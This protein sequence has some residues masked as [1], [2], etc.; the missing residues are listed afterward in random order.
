MILICT[1][2]IAGA[3]GYHKSV[4]QLA[5]GLHGA[6]YSVALLGF[7]GPS[8]GSARA[9]PLWPL[10]PGVPAFALQTLAA[11]GG[12]LL[13]RNY[14]LALSG[15]LGSTPYGFTANQLAVLR[16][17]NAAL[18]P[19]DTI[20]FT[21]AVQA[22]AFQSALETDERRPRT[23]L[24]I[25]GDYLHHSFLWDL[26][27]ET[28]GV[29]DRLQTVADGLRA[30]FV[31]TFDDADVVYVPNFPGDDGTVVE[32]VEHDGVNIALPA[33]FQARKNQLD[34]VRA[35]ALVD[36]ESVHLTLWGGVNRRNPYLVEV[37][38]LIT[39]LGLGDR[40][41]LPGFGTEKDVYSTADI[42][43]MTS[44][45]EGFA[46]PLIEATYQGRPTVAYDF[47]FGPRE[48]IDDGDSGF[49]VPQGDVERLAARLAELAADPE[50]RARFGA[51]ARAIFD[52]RFATAAVAERYRAMLGPESGNAVD[53][54]KLFSTEGSDPVPA[55]AIT[56]RQRRLGPRRVHQVTVS[57]AVQLHDV[58]L[59]DGR[60]VTTPRV[61]STGG[62][63]RIEFDGGGA[64]VLSYATAPGSPER[65]YLA[66][67]TA[68]HE[69]QVLP[70]LRRDADYGDG[71]PPV[72]DTV[73]AAAG[74]L[75]RMAP[76]ELGPAAL[77]LLRK[78]RRDVEWKVRQVASSRSAASRKGTSPAPVPAVG[79]TEGPT[80]P[81]PLGPVPAPS[82]TAAATSSATGG[83]TATA[84]TE[85][86]SKVS[87]SVLRTARRLVTVYS[88]TAI[89]AVAG[90][91]KAPGGSTRRELPRHPRY[92]VV[93]GEDN[94]GTPINQHGGVAVRNSGT[95]ARPTVTVKGEYDWLVLRDAAT[96]R[97]VEPP[98][99]YGEFFERFCA[100]EREHQLFERTTSDGTH[101][102]EL[103]RA[104]LVIQLAEALG[105]WGAGPAIGTPLRDEYE[106]AKRLT[107]A[108]PA[109]RVVF[110]YARRGQS[111]YR[112]AAFR[113]D[114]TMFIVQPEPDGY[115][116]AD[117]TNV[118]YPLHEFNQWRSDWRRRWAHQRVPD[119]DARPFEEALTREL[120]IRVDLGT[121]LRNRLVKF[122]DERDF[123]TPVFER[124]R[125]E[126][127]LIPASHWL[128]GIS[129]AAMRAGARVSD[130]QYADTGSYHPTFWFGGTPRYGA[131]RFYAWSEL[132]ASRTNVFQ[133]HVI[134][135]RRQPELRAALDADDVLP[136]TWDVCVISQ[137]RVLR[138]MIAFVAD[139]V[140]ERPGLRVV[141]APHP[142][143]RLT[144]ESD[145]AAAG[146]A[147]KVTV[148]PHDTLSTIQRSAIC[149][150]GYSTSMWEAAALGRPTY[151]IPLPGYELTLQDVESGLF[152]VA[153]SPHDL[154]PYEVPAARRD[155]FTVD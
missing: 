125:P 153:R 6:G 54:V 48:S 16:E 51:Q 132:W 121:H 100:A 34:A 41:H 107:T 19:E 124:V 92:P 65:F 117:D 147:G 2:E 88:A 66:S 37:E 32:T 30:Q 33:S 74:G 20:V 47:D 57:S 128:P 101:V 150:G 91:A 11:D 10:H 145:L 27:R 64:E 12:R 141:I 21:S 95:P 112:T 94:F 61:H 56:H 87:P 15:H 76:R 113:D 23:V 42:V 63:T 28:R 70:Y 109:R 129:L 46:Y 71:T 38:D 119:V 77:A 60:R 122:V 8:D 39:S 59:D 143:Q 102:W 86:S 82:T 45:S 73:F 96:E 52:E 139:V 106:G 4:V 36:D 26:L 137:A 105:Y 17:L 127:V 14:H 49:L 7:L 111:G 24:Q 43:L 108:P 25:H 118:T 53:L 75:R 68:D 40:V 50:M 84:A 151:T 98:F 93:S 62:A 72:T 155:I 13:H 110:D 133:E 116:E 22:L 5:N 80:P 134:T 115:P 18:T 152:R 3:T 78:A 44:L 97:R 136:P 123:W 89:N 35:L 144:M 142:T 146:L 85:P 149:V 79:Q 120:G 1:N 135:P 126:E 55:A 81:A 99:E 140:R 83:S 29:I 154:V 90:L 69:F 67:S 138:R 104:A 58:R 31:P 103:G 114:E 131:S 9:L 130:V 148:S